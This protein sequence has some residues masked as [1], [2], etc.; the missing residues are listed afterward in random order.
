MSKH[1]APSVT[2]H[3]GTPIQQADAAPG[4]AP[5]FDGMQNDDEDK[6]K[7]P[8]GAVWREDGTVLLT[9]RKPVPQSIET[10]G[11]GP[12][13]RKVTSVVFQPMT[14]AA[15]LRIQA[16]KDD[17]QR[18]LTM[19][20]ESSGLV[21]FTGDGIFKRMDARDFVASTVIASIFTNPG[22]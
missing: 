9:L 4:P 3:S 17:A 22:L 8:K 18:G 13:E 10:P 12:T 21:G 15:M 14:G 5:A 11:E 19:M 20:K 6:P 2:H 1:E 16:C 7:L